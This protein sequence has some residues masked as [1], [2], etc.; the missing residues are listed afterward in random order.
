MKRRPAIFAGLHV[1][2]PVDAAGLLNPPGARPIVVAVE[3]KSRHDRQA[4]A[5][6]HV[7]AA[8]RINGPGARRIAVTLLSVLPPAGDR[9]ALAGLGV[10]KHH[11]LVGDRLGVRYCACGVSPCEETELYFPKVRRH[12]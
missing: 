8:G 12:K 4:L 7:S 3:L 5:G 10:D 2:D 11:T 1:A 6:L 9:Q